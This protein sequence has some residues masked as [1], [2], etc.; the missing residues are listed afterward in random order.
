MSGKEPKITT[1]RPCPKKNPSKLG[2]QCMELSRLT[3]LQVVTVSPHENDQLNNELGFKIKVKSRI[4][5]FQDNTL[6][7]YHSGIFIICA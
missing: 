7:I 4:L 5:Y 3:D 6:G 1:K 2:A